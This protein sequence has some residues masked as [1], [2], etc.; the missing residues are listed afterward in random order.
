MFS[1]LSISI[2]SYERYEAIERNILDNLDCFLNEKIKIYIFDDSSSDTLK[3]KVKELIKVYPYIEYIKNK[4]TLGHDKNFFQAIN[5]P[6]SEFIWVIGDST[7][8]NPLTFGKIL[9]VIEN[10]NPNLICVN[11]D[12]RVKDY[13]SGEMTN[14]NFILENFGWHLTYTG[15]TI[16]KRE[17]LQHSFLDEANLPKNFPQIYIIFNIVNIYKNNGIYWL[18]SN[19]I[20]AFRKSQSY[21]IK[22]SINVFIFDWKK[23]INKLPDT[24]SEECKRNTE[25]SHSVKTNIFDFKMFV[26]LRSYGSFNINILKNSRDAILA[27]TSLNNVILLLIALTPQHIL[28]VLLKIWRIL[29]NY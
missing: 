23:A 7:I 22:D 24:Y 2:P 18:N 6:E 20:S 26:I 9:E 28:F 14:P 4:N 8:I 17:C 21:W 15:A 1:N 12:S 13:E 5:T 10:N 16:Y 11:K 25:L 29:K 27:H 3:N 19:C